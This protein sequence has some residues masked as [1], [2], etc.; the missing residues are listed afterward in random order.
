MSTYYETRWASNVWVV[1]GEN[2]SFTYSSC[3]TDR[4]YGARPVI[5]MPKSV[6]SS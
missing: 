6:F 3:Q 2:G 5:T 1:K 4:G